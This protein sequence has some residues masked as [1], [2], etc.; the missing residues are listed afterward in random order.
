MVYLGG[1]NSIWLRVVVSWFVAGRVL[2]GTIDW[3]PDQ[4][5]DV[6]IT[7]ANID[8]ARTLLGY[9]PTTRPDAGIA[10]YWAWL[11]RLHG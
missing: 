9:A 11:Q 4:P 2:G 10:R 3:Q 7:Y 5:G 6:P 8:R 1:S